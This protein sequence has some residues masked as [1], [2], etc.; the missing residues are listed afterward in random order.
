[1]LKHKTLTA[2]ELNA[3][4]S[5]NKSFT[6]IDVV[7][8]E[9]FQAKHLPNAASACIYEVSFLDNVKK[10]IS[11]NDKPI[12]V[13]STSEKCMASTVAVERL[14]DAGYSNVYEYQGGLEEWEAKG[15][16]VVGDNTSLW[17]DEEGLLPFHAKTYAV[18]S[19]KSILQWAG[20]NIKSTH[21]GT[22][23]ISEGEIKTK[24][25]SV[26]SGQFIIDMNTLACDD[27]IDETYNEMLIAHLKSD[28]FFS[29]EKYPFARFSITTTNSISGYTPGSYNFNVKGDLTIKD[30]TRGVEFPSIINANKD[31]TLIF[32][33]QLDIDRTDWNVL[34]GSGKYFQK[35]GMHLVNDIVGIQFRVICR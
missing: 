31:G 10:E 33:A 21:S 20:R 25:A 29:V 5:N 14:I 2:D 1:M 23:R 27:I 19:S 22:L 9:Y 34:Y 15:Y 24:D 13:Y 28:D 16:Q 18:D 12:V 11:A 7:P 6:L 17:E 3:W 26:T 8:K 30:V 32:L 4:I 35:L